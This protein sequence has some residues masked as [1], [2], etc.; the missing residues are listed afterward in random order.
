MDAVQAAAE[1]AD[2]HA[3]KFESVSSLEFLRI[4]VLRYDPAAYARQADEAIAAQYQLIAAAR[5]EIETLL[6]ERVAARRWHMGTLLGLV[7]LLVVIGIL[8]LWRMGRS[9]VRPLIFAMRDA[10]AIASGRLDKALRDIGGDEVGRVRQS[11]QH[12]QES[13]RQIV[14][15]IRENSESVANAAGEI[16][17]STREMSARTESQAA[18]LEETAASM[19]EMNRA[20]QQN[21]QLSAQ[22]HKLAA[23]AAQAAA[24]GGEVVG[25]VARTMENIDAS[26]RKIADI[27]GL[28]DSIAFQTNILSLNAAIEA[29][30]A[31]EQGRG[32]AVV[33]AEVRAL[34]QRSGTAS[35]EIH[36]LINES[37]A[38]VQAGTRETQEAAH[39]MQDIVKAAHTVEETLQQI[40]AS[41]AEQ[42]HGIAQVCRAVEQMNQGTQQGAAMIEEIA[43]TVDQLAQQAQQLTSAVAAFKLP[44]ENS[45]SAAAATARDA[46]APGYAGYVLGGLQA[47]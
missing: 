9:I 29:A 2:A 17:V 26:S 45:A 25:K 14:F 15:A 1:A 16:A 34:A 10:D 5:A 40:S 8:A 27:V 47:A 37:V 18:G 38:R 31:G 4:E 20:V 43:A 44:D 32:F 21:D 30:R 36:A 12:M 22:A 42:R 11:M 28:I 39:A 19:E 7:G 24:R 35:K 13:L 23:S 41:S 3:T 33:A 46:D 6:S